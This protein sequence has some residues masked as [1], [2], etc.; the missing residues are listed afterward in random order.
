VYSSQSSRRTIPPAQPRFILLP[1]KSHLS[2]C[3]LWRCPTTQ[4]LANRSWAPPWLLT[5]HEPEEW[6]GLCGLVT[7]VPGDASVRWWL[8]SSTHKD[9]VTRKLRFSM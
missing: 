4:T 8:T 2:I 9:W 5:I 3:P 7:P 6:W 1:L